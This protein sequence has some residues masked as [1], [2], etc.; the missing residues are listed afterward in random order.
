MEVLRLEEI[1][2][3]LW[4]GMFVDWVVV[5]VMAMGILSRADVVHLVGGSALHAAGLGLIAGEGDP[6]NAVGVDGVSGATN[7]LLVSSGVD[8]DGVFW[9]SCVPLATNAPYN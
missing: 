6:E 8:D 1:S 2:H 7:V 3:V 4:L 9:G 5:V